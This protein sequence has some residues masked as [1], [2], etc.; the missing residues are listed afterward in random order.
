M[1]SLALIALAQG[2]G[3][4]VSK[5]TYASSDPF[6]GL[7]FMMKY[8]PTTAA[9]DSCHGNTCTKYNMM[10]Q[11]D[12]GRAQLVDAGF[13]KAKNCKLYSKIGGTSISL[14]K[15]SLTRPPQIPPPSSPYN[16]CTYSTKKGISSGVPL[17]D[18]FAPSSDTCCKACAAVPECAGAEWSSSSSELTEEGQAFV[19]MQELVASNKGRRHLQGPEPSK[20]EGFGLHLVNVTNSKTTGGIDV[21]ELEAKIS[22]N[23]GDMS[24]Y[25][26]FMDYSVQLFTANLPAYAAAFAADGVKTLAASWSA[27]SADSLAA[28]TWYSL[29]VHVP[30]SQ[31]I[32]ELI[33]TEAPSTSADAMLVSLEP[34]MSPRNVKLYADTAKDALNILHATSV[35]RATSNISAIEWFYTTVVGATLVHSVDYTGVSRRC[36]GWK[37]AKSDVCFVQRTAT[38]VAASAAFGVEDFETMLWSTHAAIIGSDP[39]IADDKYNDNHYAIDEMSVSGDH[40]SSYVSAHSPFPITS[41]S[42]WAYDCDQDY[43]IDPTGWAIQVDMMVSYPACTDAASRKAAIVEAA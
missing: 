9:I 31:M 18:T 13:Y 36:Y 21:A 26:P 28:S 20:G 40:I 35:T 7:A 25:N 12:Q 34:R 41:K 32:I 19:V 1:L 11:K 15:T 22:A 5:T 10:G 27:S 8:L 29:F 4:G 30:N 24:A 2:P 17:Y 43:L 6:T 37:E 42:V 38:G 3:D 23:L 33:G 39:T 16:D 14:S